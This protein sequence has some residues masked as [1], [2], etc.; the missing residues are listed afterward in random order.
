MDFSGLRIGFVPMNNDL[1]HPFDLRNFIY[2]SRRRDIKF[3]IADPAADYDFVVLSPSA[4][5]STW[6]RYRGKAKIIYLIVDSYLAIP[7]YDIKGALRGIAKYISGE[8][9]NLRFNYSEAVKEMCSKADAVLCTTMEQKEGIQAY[10]KN[11]HI[12]M[13][14]HSRLVREVKTDYSIGNRINLVWEG[15]A[16]NIDG[17]RYIKKALS[18]LRKKYPIALHLITD[19]DRMKHMNKYG[20]VY[21]IDYI[22]DIFGEDY[23]SNTSTGNNSFI[24]LYQWNL[25]MLSRIVTG[26]DIAIVPVDIR[27]PFKLGK[28][29]NKLV[30]FWRMGMPVIASAIPAYERAMAG[31]G[32]DMCCRSDDEWCLKL[33]KLIVD[34][35]ARKAAATQGKRCADTVYGEEQYLKQW[36]DLFQSVLH[37]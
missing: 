18:V 28:P 13:E 1:K 10:C 24:Y 7:Q 26:C 14:F 33:E 8:H 20:R 32:L 27:N 22:R 6:S 29:E 16:E 17:F 25:E 11:V 30:L 34:E 19:L 21:T 4:D 9:K 2:Y 35:G 37:K 12:I 31:C 3:E 15:F 23:S 36:D 5:I